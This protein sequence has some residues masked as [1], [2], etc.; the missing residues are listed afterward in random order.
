MGKRYSRFSDWHR[1]RL[2]VHVDIIR[3]GEVLRMIHKARGLDENG[4]F[5]TDVV[6]SGDVPVVP[7]ESDVSQLPY[8]ED[9]IQ[10]GPGLYQLYGLIC[11]VVRLV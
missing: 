5:Q 1:F 6:I 7:A 9:F 4:V 2:V 11:K 8:F 10:T 3:V